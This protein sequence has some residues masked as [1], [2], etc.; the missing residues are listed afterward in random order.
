MLFS[1]LSSALAKLSDTT[2]RLEMISILAELFRKTDPDIIDKVVYMIQGK[3]YPDYVGLEIGIAEKLAA[4]ALANVS[5][6]PVEE[7][8]KLTSRMG[9][10]GDVAEQ[11]AAKKA[12]VTLFSEPLTIEKVYAA[13]EIGRAFV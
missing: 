4:K 1:E 6:V 11:L 10:L 2:K 13:L 12:Q 7:V 3:L 9:D 8:E 5:G